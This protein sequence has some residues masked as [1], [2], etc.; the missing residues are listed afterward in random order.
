[1]R[2]SAFLFLG[3]ALSTSPALAGASSTPF[4]YTP[5]PAMRT[6]SVQDL[7]SRVR[8]TC[9]STQAKIQSVSTEAVAKP[10]SC[11]ATQLM[12]S[13]DEAEVAAYRGTGV[14]NDSARGKAIA[15]IDACKLRR[16]I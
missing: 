6:E 14:F 5:D 7:E 16:P 2:F 9:A 15:A 8:R 10:C 12:R 4:G 3:F 1:M 11:Y 13:L